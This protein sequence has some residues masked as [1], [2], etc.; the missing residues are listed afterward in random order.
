M[1]IENENEIIDAESEY[2]YD[3]LD[4]LSATRNGKIAALERDTREEVNRRLQARES[5]TKIL[6]WLNADPKTRARLDR[7]FEGKPITRQNLSKW[8]R[9]GFVEWKKHEKAVKRQRNWENLR[10]AGYR[11]GQGFLELLDMFEERLE[12]LEAEVRKSKEEGSQSLSNFAPVPVQATESCQSAL[13]PCQ[14]PTASRQS[15]SGS[16]RVKGE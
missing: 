7:R 11:S 8:R 13:G 15:P 4:P 16:V 5:S 6:A 12:E 9:G 1:K 3:T 2:E 14:R 10:A